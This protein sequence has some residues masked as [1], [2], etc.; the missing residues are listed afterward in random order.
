[1]AEWGP[2]IDTGALAAQ[3]WPEAAS[4]KLGD[5]VVARGLQD[6]LDALAATRCPPG[7]SRY[8]AAPY[9]ALAGALLLAA[10]AREPA[11]AAL[12]LGQLLTLSTLNGGK[13][14]ALTQGDL[15]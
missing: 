10:L 6:E 5:L 8:H 1:M 7:R 14:D 4:L 9:D 12:S 11:V 13:R 15:F 2:W 3:F